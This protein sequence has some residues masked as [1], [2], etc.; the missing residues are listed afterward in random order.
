MFFQLI[1]S[2]ALLLVGISLFLIR[3]EGFIPRPSGAVIRYET[4]DQY[5]MRTTYL[6][7]LRRGMLIAQILKKKV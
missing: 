7:A 1:T 6:A 4:R 2:I 5:L 3:G